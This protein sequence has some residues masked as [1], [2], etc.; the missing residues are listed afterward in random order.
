M[1]EMSY[2]WVSMS[3]KALEAQIGAFVKH[4]RLAQNKSQ[5]VLATAAGISRSTLSLLERGESVTLSTLIQLLRILG[6]L[7]VM[8][9]FVIPRSISP[10]MLA[11][12]EHKKYRR[13]RTKRTEPESL[14]DW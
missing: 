9:V 11:K 12:E 1:S 14:S 2:N 6:Q 3:D 7:Q 8:D 10:L 5:E 4:H 13:A